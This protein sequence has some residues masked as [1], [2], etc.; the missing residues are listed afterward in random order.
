MRKYF[1][2]LTVLFPLGLFAQFLNFYTPNSNK[3]LPQLFVYDIQQDTNGYYWLA[4]GEGLAKF[5][6]KTVTTPYYPDS[7][8]TKFG[9]SITLIG[10]QVWVGN[11]DG[12]IHV[13]ERDS[14][15]KIIPISQ[16]KILKIIPLDTQKIVISQQLIYTLKKDSIKSLSPLKEGQYIQDA[17]Y[18]NGKLYIASNFGVEL[19]D[20]K[21]KTRNTLGKG[22]FSKLSIDANKNIWAFG[23]EEALNVS[24]RKIYAYSIETFYQKIN[25][26]VYK[27]GLFWLS[28]NTG[29]DVLKPS[30]NLSTLNT[31]QSYTEESGLPGNNILCT[32]LSGD[33]LWVS[34]IGNGLSYLNL[35]ANFSLIKD[36]INLGKTVAVLNNGNKVWQVHENGISTYLYIQNSLV[37]IKETPFK[38]I[39]ISAAC[40]YMGMVYVGT[41]DGKLF[42]FNDILRET[43]IKRYH[44]IGHSILSLDAKGNTICVS[45]QY[46]GCY[47][48]KGGRTINYNTKNGILHNDVQRTFISKNGDLWFLC[49][50]SGI[51][52]AKP[53]GAII[54]HLTINEGL[55]SLEFTDIAEDSE[56]NVWISTQGAGLLRITPQYEIISFPTAAGVSSDYL[57]GIDINKQDLIYF[58]ARNSF[59]VL[60]QDGIEVFTAKQIGHTI[61]FSNKAINAQ[62]AKVLLGTDKGLLVFNAQK[63]AI[64]SY[65]NIN[66]AWARINDTRTIKDGTSLHYGDYKL[67]VQPDIISANP[68]AEYNASYY[69]EGFDKEWNTYNGNTII[70][71]SLKGGN[72]TLKVKFDDKEE[73]QKSFSFYIDV[74]FWE[75]PGFYIIILLLSIAVFFAVLKIRTQRLERINKILNE[76]VQERTSVLE[77]RNKNLEQ[78]S[79]ALSH[80]LK[81]PTVNL[82]ELVK[83]LKLDAK[84]FDEDGKE[85]IG[86]IEKASNHLYQ[87]LIDF[88]EVLRTMNS[89]DDI[90]HQLNL[91]ALCKEIID[92]IRIIVEQNKTSFE[93]NFE[94]TEIEYNKQRLYSVL[95][96][97][98]TNAIKYRKPNI[99]P[100]IKISS[101]QKDGSSYL[102]VQDNGLGIDLDTHGEKLFTMFHRT[103][104]HTEG[105]GVGL[106]LVKNIV[107][108]YGGTI[109][110]EST[111]NEGCTFILKLN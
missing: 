52:I 60:F 30:E 62:G 61:N 10:K 90:K 40:I 54:Y 102:T 81:N 20:L 13:F 87:N 111:V 108:K 98:I 94:L 91:K 27:N 44:S 73:I 110:V 43:S 84:D 22:N 88:L 48:N 46:E 3:D 66:I 41:T 85:L 64:N 103:H 25:Q 17:L 69:L 89:T 100:V 42:T 82:I 59:N 6:G 49:S 1:L 75:K 9:S 50:G 63:Q 83:I 34:T 95:Y 15:R 92:S 68:L 28:T 67:S 77:E 96:N 53:N 32:N 38:N 55:P 45:V 72:Y 11:I 35:R 47:V 23:N 24:S 18:V 99:T 86:Q 106:H 21:K 37:P 39:N 19:L 76:R 57:Y 78:F 104:T 107:E 36:K 2:L 74:P 56:G 29:L 31:E 4:T 16:S 93:F 7:I 71:Q 26:V 97:L 105:T 14:L 109:R 51:S 79:Y 5:N 58:A 70:Y 101:F 65:S 80:D 12:N 8:E 33:D